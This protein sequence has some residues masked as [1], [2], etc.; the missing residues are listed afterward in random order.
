M[1][2]KKNLPTLLI[3]TTSIG[4]VSTN[5][6]YFFFYVLVFFFFVK[7]KEPATSPWTNSITFLPINVKKTYLVVKTEKKLLFFKEFNQF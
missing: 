6:K 3:W 7:K 2:K 1:K 4:N 5:T